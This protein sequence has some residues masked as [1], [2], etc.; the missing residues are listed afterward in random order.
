MNIFQNRDSLFGALD[1]EVVNDSLLSLFRLAKQIRLRLGKQ[2]YLLDNYLTHFFEGVGSELA[3]AAADEGNHACAE[4]QLLLEHLLDGTQPRKPH[5]LYPRMQE[6]YEKCA[7]TL[8]FQE[9]Y[10]N[11]CQLI[12]M[13]ADELMAY[14]TAEYVKKQDSE[15]NGVVDG[16]YLRETYDKISHL[17]GEAMMEELNQR[18]KQRFLIAPVA[19]AFAQGFTD[20]LL[21]KLSNRDFETSRQMFQLL[22]DF[23]PSDEGV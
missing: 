15:L 2:G 17:A 5:P 14:A 6:A 9:K 13:L 18:I 7:D 11:L 23:L 19:A 8:I 22:M 12:F 21:C 1:S 10:T 16:I 20:E 3:F 4:F